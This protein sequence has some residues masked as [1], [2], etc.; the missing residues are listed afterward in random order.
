METQAEKQ[1]WERAE[2]QEYLKVEII[3][4]GYNT[5]DFA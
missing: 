3:D 4:S 1:L 2:K 5:V